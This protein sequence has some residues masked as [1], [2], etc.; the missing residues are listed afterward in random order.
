MKHPPRLDWACRRFNPLPSREGKILKKGLNRLY[1]KFDRSFISPDPLECVPLKGR[2]QDIELSAFIAAVFAY[3][4]ADLIVRNVNCILDELGPR[5]YKTLSSGGYKTKFKKF[6]YRFH[7]R[8]D[9]LWL[10]SRL[11]KIY[12][13]YGTLEEAFTSVEGTLK[14]RMENFSG[15]FANGRRQKPNRKFLVPSPSGSACKRTNLFLRW[16]VRK[17]SVDLGLWKKLKPS[18]LVIPLDVHVLR[19]AHR[20]GLVGNGNASFARAEELT[21]NL[22]R[23]DSNDP[24]RYDFAICSLGKLGHCRKTPV[25]AN[26]QR[27]VLEKLC[28]KR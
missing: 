16:M 25:Q 21:E 3:G 14:E 28:T 20:V 2:F 7:K 9:L 10:F 4:R 24:V 18:D 17:D 23:F 1:D 27:C 26:C 5:P 15:L 13:K 12:K 6:K 11:E 19:I 22:R 8:P